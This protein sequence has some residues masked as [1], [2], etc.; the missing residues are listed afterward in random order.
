MANFNSI[1]TAY[2]VPYIKEG[3]MA[4]KILLL[5][6]FTSLSRTYS[7]S[8][9]MGMSALPD[10]YTTYLP[11]GLWPSGKALVPTV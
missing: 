9:T 2:L 1:I 4:I 10:I 6:E 5:G 7:I 3:Y 11:S 8:Y